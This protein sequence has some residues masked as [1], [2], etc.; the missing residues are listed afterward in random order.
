MK[1]NYFLISIFAILFIP[2]L[3]SGLSSTDI[4]TQ[5]INEDTEPINIAPENYLNL[6]FQN[7][8]FYSWNQMPI[9]QNE[10]HIVGVFNT[11]EESFLL[12]NFGVFW[13]LDYQINKFHRIND[14]YGIA[15]IKYFQDQ[16]KNGYIDRNFVVK[17][18]NNQ[19]KITSSPINTENFTFVTLNDNYILASGLGLDLIQIDNQGVLVGDVKILVPP[20]EKEGFATT[21]FYMIDENSGFFVDSDR[22]FSL[23]KNI[24]TKPEPDRQLLDIKAPSKTGKNAVVVSEKKAVLRDEQNNLYFVDIDQGTF[25]PWLDEESNSIKSNAKN[26]AFALDTEDFILNITVTNSSSEYGTPYLVKINEWKKLE[27][28]PE[29]KTISNFMITDKDENKGVFIDKNLNAT[30]FI[31]EN[32]KFSINTFGNLNNVQFINKNLIFGSLKGHDLLI[33]E[34]GNNIWAKMKSVNFAPN[35]IRTSDNLLNN[36]IVVEGEEPIDYQNTYFAN[37][38]ASI[39]VTDDVLKQ[40]TIKNSTGQRILTPP[41]GSHNINFTFSNFDK[42]QVTI[43]FNNDVELFYQVNIINFA[44]KE[45]FKISSSSSDISSYVGTTKDVLYDIKIIDQKDT[46]TISDYD[47]NFL[48]YIELTIYGDAKDMV[49]KNVYNLQGASEIKKGDAT[50]PDLFFGLKTVNLLNQVNWVYLGF[51]SNGVAP[52]PDFWDTEK[53][54]DLM[55]QALMHRYLERDLRKMNSQEI[56]KLMDDSIGWHSIATQGKAIVFTIISIFG[57]SIIAIIVSIIVNSYFDRRIEIAQVEKNK[58][59]KNTIDL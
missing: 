11:K 57:V 17:L 41:V 19:I 23:L 35:S 27:E 31:Y 38:S 14:Q 13:S 44:N 25:E 34:A 39:S 43:E 9:E 16:E 20:Y 24:R 4:K 45:L 8:T 59:F 46:F 47:Y 48:E 55:Y 51:S 22:S 32:E 15:Q 1:K 12:D 29:I 3:I 56:E 52:M 28:I 6:S 37:G 26:I 42:Y 53:G 10:Q 21:A 36:M 49:V 5:E 58:G 54:Q 7:G 30:N 50:D 40:V 33:S 18:E 2:G